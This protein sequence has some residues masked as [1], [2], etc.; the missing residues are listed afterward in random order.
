MT[1]VARATFMKTAISLIDE[2]AHELNGLQVLF[3]IWHE[4]TPPG[5]R[6]RLRSRLSAMSRLIERMRKSQLRNMKDLE[7][8]AIRIKYF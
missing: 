8:V 6:R 2:L 4:R 3:N 1:A 7:R 5:V